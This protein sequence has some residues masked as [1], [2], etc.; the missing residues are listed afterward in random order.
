MTQGRDPR[1][2]SIPPAARP[3]AEH[4]RALAAANTLEVRLFKKFSQRPLMSVWHGQDK[5]GNDVLLTV[6]DACGTPPE[7]NRVMHAADSLIAMSGT[8][9]IQ[10]VHRVLNEGDAFTADFLGAGTAA[11]LV[12]LRWSPSRR[13]EFVVKVC[14]ALAALHEAG[15][16][17][18]CLC[19]DNVLMN[20]DLNPVLT[21][22]GM[23]SVA[24]SLGGDSENF[25]G[26]GAYASAEAVSGV[27]DASSDIYSAGRLL[28][29]V[30]LDRTP[31]DASD[32]KELEAKAPEISAIVRRCVGTPAQRYASIAELAA[33]LARCRHKL[34]PAAGE[35]AK[36]PTEPEVHAKPTRPP[37]AKPA[38]STAWV[39]D[40]AGEK[41]AAPWWVPAA[42]VA[43]L[44]AVGAFGQLL[45]ARTGLPHVVIQVVIA[46]A[47]V[48]VTMGLRTG[49]GG[50]VVIS[51]AA[52]ALAFG[53]DPSARFSAADADDVDS[54]DAA[55]RAFVSHGGK[56][57]HGKRLTWADFS[58]LDL[59]SADLG[60]A[61]LT[62]ASF[63][64]AKLNHAS[65]TGTSFIQANLVGA[66]LTGVS[67]DQAYG[68]ETA[69]CDSA[70]VL[71]LG[72]VCNAEERVRR[73]P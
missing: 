37:A 70:T 41:T 57:L 38:K 24:E 44:V 27:P 65:V 15:L 18:G 17:H 25:F 61:D 6:V 54:R 3:S 5:D 63:V 51:I 45:T 16:V 71:P 32:F 19:P 7:R 58:H 22:T 43:I 40:D 33:D 42:S 64:G 14:E 66:D 48:G 72:W 62:G 46:I 52:F 49:M 30:M 36:R 69:Q 20:D 21:E 73:A 34:A 1:L 26:Y 12:V 39:A 9:G 13:L 47:A 56:D 67:L 35:M 55:A 29:F 8:D 59:T 50:R 2:T 28:S 10:N 31:D 53:V 23:V 68:V 11:D 60:G 4:V